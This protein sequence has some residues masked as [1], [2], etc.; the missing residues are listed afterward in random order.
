[1][2]T[3]A[4]LVRALKPCAAYSTTNMIA[5][6]PISPTM[7]GFDPATSAGNMNLTRMKPA[8]PSPISE[9]KPRQR[10]TAITATANSTVKTIS[11]VRRSKSENWYWAG[12]SSTGG[13]RISL[14]TCPTSTPEE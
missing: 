11:G 2:P 4:V 13:T 10:A 5:E 6:E 8:K 3:S 1:M 14:I 9:A 12:W 7:I